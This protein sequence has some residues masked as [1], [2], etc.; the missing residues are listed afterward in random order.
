MSPNKI[1]LFRAIMVCLPVLFFVLVE[2]VLRLIGYGV[3]YPLFIQTP[4]SDNYIL[5]SPSI[6]Q[7]YFPAQ[8]DTPSVTMEANLFL[9]HKPENGLRIF[10][11]GGSTA[12]GFPYGIGAAPAGMLDQRLKQTFPHR[13]V[14]VIN[15]A[16]S[17]VNTYTLLDFVDEIID[18]R[19]D[20]VLL[21]AGHNE[22]LGILG[23][24]SN[25]VAANSHAANLIFLWIKD[26]RL[27]QLLQNLYANIRE[28][29]PESEV[30]ADAKS[31]SRTFMARVAR[32]KNIALGSELYQAGI[33]QF[34][35]NL[36]L[37]L[38]K[39]TE[40]G[41]PVYLATLASNLKDQ[42]PF[43]S[44]PTPALTKQ[45]LNGLMDRALAGASKA[46]LISTAEKILSDPDSELSA[47]AHF[48]VAKALEIS[49]HLSAAHPYFLKAKELDL[50]RFRAP[51]I[52]NEIIKSK[53]EQEGV[54]LVDYQFTLAAKSPARI[55]GKEFMLEHLH[56]NLQGYFI[57]ADSFYQALMSNTLK[58]EQAKLVSTNDAWRMRPV[59]PAEEY[60]GFARIV[61]LKSD[62][63]FTPEPT[64]FT[65]PQPAD[66]Q[67]E[68]GLKHF[69]KEIDWI[70]M[71]ADSYRGYVDERNLPMILK[72]AQILADAM[73]YNHLANYE[74][75][76]LL[77][78]DGRSTE[79]ILYFRRALTEDPDNSI[80]QNAY[81]SVID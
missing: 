19:P 66:W 37:I 25:Y 44:A 21:Y 48:M 12:A 18:Q 72:S 56:P 68:L 71:I 51:D 11:Q 53:A 41:I 22:Y 34:E 6:I 39:Y 78:Q 76:R 20:A 24:G 8:A 15:T 33:R 45:R 31:T 52:I 4:D 9:R 62:Y 10:V 23:V 26:F 16:M 5:A 2:L 35:D 36:D 61:Q 70:T 64:E 1:W 50:L 17:A 57:L 47:D 29:I 67:Q 3:S 63:P 80:Y 74:Y 42:Q 14:E 59:L 79:A 58:D 13:H 46:E 49:T 65:L 55:V 75:G 40:A 73:P 27:Y 54:F 28:S 69:Q 77:V 32:E 7:R 38:D 43:A 30:S 60:Y 81:A